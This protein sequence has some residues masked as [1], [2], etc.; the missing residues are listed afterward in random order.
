MFGPKI[1]YAEAETPRP[2]FP[3]C[4]HPRLPGPGHEG[5]GSA[6]RLGVVAPD[7]HAVCRARQHA[8]LVT[9]PTR[10]RTRAL[11]QPTRHPTAQVDTLRTNCRQRGPC[12]FRTAVLVTPAIW[13]IALRSARAALSRGAGRRRGA[14]YL[15]RSG[16]PVQHRTAMS[17]V[18]SPQR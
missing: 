3:G 6:L 4:A 2:P 16:R 14:T 11:S 15:L 10:T 17:N 13:P 1:R 7:D 5:I 8:C 12:T 9:Q 18:G